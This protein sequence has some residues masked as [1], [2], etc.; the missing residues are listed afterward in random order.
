[1]RQIIAMHC[2]TVLPSK[3]LFMAI[4]SRGCSHQISWTGAFPGYQMITVSELSRSLPDLMLGIRSGRDLNRHEPHRAQVGWSHQG[5][6]G[7]GGGG[8]PVCIN[9]GEGNKSLNA[10]FMHQGAGQGT[11]GVRQGLQAS[12]AYSLPEGTSDQHSKV[13]L[14]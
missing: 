14:K 3:L 1:M 5:K 11:M 9:G 6:G 13:H 12:Y 4:L 10:A 7:G 2:T 8:D